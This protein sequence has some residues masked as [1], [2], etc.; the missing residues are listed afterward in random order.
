MPSSLHQFFLFWKDNDVEMVWADNKPFNT[1][2][3]NLEARFYDV[4]LG[5]LKFSRRKVNGDPRNIHFS[6][7]D[8]ET[9]VQEHS[10]LIYK[11]KA[12]MPYTYW[13]MEKPIIEEIDD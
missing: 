7:E 13:P 8:M 11:E 4:N 1:Y 9:K 3:D 5:P 6:R 10:D 12:I 2:S